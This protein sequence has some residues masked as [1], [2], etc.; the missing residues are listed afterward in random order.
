MTAIPTSAGTAGA[1]PRAK[2]PTLLAMGSVSFPLAALSLPLVVMIPEHYTNALGLNLAVVGSIFTSVRILDI[3][4]DPL[5]GA[6]MDR[7]KTPFGRYKP[8]LIVGAPLLMAFTYMLF[9]AKPGVGPT[10]LAVGLIAAFMIWSIM[11]LAQLALASGLTKSYDERSGVYSW[12]Q[13]AFLAGTTAVM[14]FPLIVA[15]MHLN[16]LSPTELMGWLIIV[17][18]VPTVLFAVLVVPD[19]GSGSAHKPIG[20][21]EYLA[22]ITRPAVLRLAAIDLLY[23]LGFGV[24]AAALVF[25]FTAVKEMD[26]SVVGI[27]L[28]AQMATAFV[29]VPL[30]VAFA[31]RF[32]KQTALWAVG[33]LA[34]LVSVAFLALPKHNLWMA[35][36]LMAIWG[37]SYAGFTVLPRSMMADAGDELRL[38]SGSDQ[39]GVLFAVLISSWK[40]GGALSVGLL[41]LALA[42]VGYKPPLMSHNTPSALLGLQLL[43]AGPSAFL[44]LLGGWLA[45]TYPLTRTRHESIRASLDAQARLGEPAP[46]TELGG[47]VANAGLEK[48]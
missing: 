17:A 43:F 28:I 29:T 20:V 40:L 39:T 8:W 3:V 15:K 31:K 11:S 48:A 10:Y 38:K 44:F 47:M 22:V 24:A 35:I 33:V 23:G 34:A 13:G 5:L 7:T 16:G 45:Y 19:K 9:M 37:V 26:R 36:V 18:T 46:L 6:A 21:K 2:W 4:I 27:L 30:V 14:A 41:F 42:K 32:D 1:S 12:V 25:F